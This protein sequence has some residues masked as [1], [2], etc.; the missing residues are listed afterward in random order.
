MTLRS[1]IEPFQVNGSSNFYRKMEFGKP[2]LGENMWEIKL[3]LRFFGNLAIHTSGLASWLQ[4]S[5]FFQHGSFSIRDGS[6]ICFWKDKW[7]GQSTLREQYPA[8]YT[9][10]RN[11][12]DTIAKVLGTSPPDVSFRKSLLGTKQAS[13]NALLIRLDSAQLSKGPDK[14][15]WN[16]TKNGK[17]LG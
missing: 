12:N 6:E 13:W 4:K 7:L 11:K 9:I 8:L 17:F 2:S 5:F 3:S 10:V 1:R 16:L 14:F 15:Q